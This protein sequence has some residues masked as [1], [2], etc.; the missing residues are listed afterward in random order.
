MKLERCLVAITTPFDASGAVDFDALQAHASW[1]IDEGV[2]GL[3]VAG[4]T[5]ES[6]TLTD[7]EKIQAM[8]SVWE[9]V[10][11]RAVVVGGAGNNS[12]AE[13][14]AF[15]ER[16]NTEAK[17]HGIM[18][19]VPYYNKPNQR[20]IAGHFKAL[21]DASRNPVMV[22]NVPGRTVVSMTL[23]TMLETCAHPNVVAIKE[24]SGDLH[25]GSKLLDALP[26]DIAVLSGDDATAMPLMVLGGA[27]IVSVAGNVAPRLLSDMCSA[28]AASDIPEARR[29][30]HK[31]AYVHDL[32]F[33]YSS[34]L[35]AKAIVSSILKFGASDIRPPLGPLNAEELEG[36]LSTAHAL[37]IKR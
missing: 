28:V 14:L 22:Y 27:G 33:R 37:E 10:S 9:A 13:S 4:T 21:A 7:D 8:N 23:E 34:P 31:V 24:A 3:V 2:S 29:L 15:I 19:V 25:L 26:S 6:A 20:G 30:A 5:G 17:V 36:V 12:T 16:V 1:L 11:D 18:S 32:M 35:T